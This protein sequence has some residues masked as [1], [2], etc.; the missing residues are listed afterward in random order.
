MV[1]A[2]N[3]TGATVWSI[4]DAKINA[5]L[6]DPSIRDWVKSSLLYALD[7]DPIDAASDAELLA[8]LLGE[9]ADALL[10]HARIGVTP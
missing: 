8:V 10:A 5:V 9:R 3:D 2:A 1:E 7:G 6:K 4:A